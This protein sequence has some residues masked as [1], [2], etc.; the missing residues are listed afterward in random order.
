M[1]KEKFERN[2]RVGCARDDPLCLDVRGL[3]LGGS[4]DEIIEWATAGSFDG[5]LH[6]LKFPGGNSM[7]WSSR[8]SG[9]SPR[10]L[11]TP[12]VVILDGVVFGGLAQCCI[13]Y[14][15]DLEPVMGLNPEFIVLCIQGD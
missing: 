9:R 12:C 6:V 7:C 10:Y 4:V 8:R 14:V 3:K 11:L 15:F 2:K 1:S 13:E 5:G